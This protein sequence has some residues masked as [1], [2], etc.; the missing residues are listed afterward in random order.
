[1][2]IFWLTNGILPIIAEKKKVEKDYGG[3]WWD[4]LSRKIVHLNEYNLIACYPSEKA[5]NIKIDNIQ[6]YSFSRTNEKNSIYFEKILL[7]EKPDIIHIFGT[8]FP[9]TLAM[10]NAAE[11]C[12][13]LNRVVINIQGLV[14]IITKHYMADLPV[15]VQYA[16]TLRDLLKWDN[17]KQQQKKFK[18]RGVYEIKALKKV[19][20]VIGR[21]DW[22]KACTTQI[23]SKIQYHFCNEILRE[24]FYKN[25]WSLEKCRKH[26]IFISQA[27]YP[28]KG[29][30]KIL[31]A[32]PIILKFFPDTVVYVAGEDLRT[33]K[34]LKKIIKQSSY[35]KYINKLIDKNGL[36]KQIKFL[37]SL[38]EQA[39]CQQ[40]LKSHIF[41]SASS[42]E[43]SPNSVGEA[44]IL[45]VPVVTSDVGGVK[46]LLTH[47]EEGFVYQAD[48][49]YM[50]AC[51]VCEIF[52]N[53][54][55]ALSFSK[56]AREHAVETHNRKENLNKT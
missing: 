4:L 44:M 13:M 53:D 51:Y 16:F 5:E 36:E 33:K 26:S 56:N 15:K 23:N 28:I 19:T 40:F 14:S 37:G 6:V 49:P 20:H 2:K 25:E 47:G 30:H 29:F 12:E 10:V 54:S 42:I 9:H 22:D 31:E 3:G 7:E 55:L 18:N 46:N 21:T 41:V 50:L 27:H 17:L 8:E 52:G 48:A 35:I 24:T 1:M 45:G 43:N 34:N 38:N 11:K 39:M 32:L